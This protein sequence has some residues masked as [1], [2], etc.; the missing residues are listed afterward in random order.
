M[1]DKIISPEFT[2]EFFVPGKSP[3]RIELDHLER[4]RFACKYAK[5]KSILDIACG[6]GYSAAMLINAGATSYLGV[7]IND[8]LVKYA[9]NTYGSEYANFVVGDIKTFNNN[10]TYDMITC[11][12]TIEHVEEYESALKNLNKLLRRGGILLISSPNRPITSPKAISNKDKP[13]NEFHKQEF[14]P[15]ELLKSLVN[16]GFTAGKNDIFGQRQRRVSSRK[17]IREISSNKIF[18]KIQ[19]LIIGSADTKT[20]PVV[21]LVVDKVP[22]YFIIVATKN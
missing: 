14:T 18:R 13:S 20:S 1:N 6:V 11:F 22:R 8:G 9:N 16:S 21:S 17:L 3:E 19:S 10:V 7:D 5:G 4:Y 12:E 2:G 15:Q